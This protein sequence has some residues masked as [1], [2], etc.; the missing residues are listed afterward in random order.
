MAQGG[1]GGGGVSVTPPEPIG[2]PID[3][4]IAPYSSVLSDGTVLMS[5]RAVLKNLRK[6][7]ENGSKNLGG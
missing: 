6:Y 1:R 5:N 4:K 2:S 7:G 3:K